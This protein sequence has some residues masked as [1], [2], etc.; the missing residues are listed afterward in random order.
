LQK[1]V[2]INKKLKNKYILSKYLLLEKQSMGTDIIATSLDGTRT[3]HFHFSHGRAR[4]LIKYG[5]QIWNYHHK[6]VRDVLIALNQVI[7][8]MM[9]AG[10]KPLIGIKAWAY[11]EDD[12]GALGNA[13][14]FHNGLEAT[15]SSD[16]LLWIDS[17]WEKMY[18]MYKCIKMHYYTLHTVRRAQPLRPFYMF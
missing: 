1:I 15:T 4:A 7:M 8:A 11:N 9:T 13:I 2:V 5:F 12:P 14:H 6:N 3:E 16:C 17:C 18:K 10:I